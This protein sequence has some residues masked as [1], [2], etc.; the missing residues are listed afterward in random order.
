MNRLNALMLSIPL[1]IVALLSVGCRQSAQPIPTPDPNT[2]QIALDY[3]QTA[4]VG[5]AILRVTLTN[6]DGSP[7]TE[8]Q[9]VEVRGDMTHAGMRPEF[10]N[11]DT[12]EA[13]VY[14]IPF[15]WS[16]GGDW[17]VTVTVTLADGSTVSRVFELSVRT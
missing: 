9:Q 13:G 4:T 17:I 15:N 5:D 1:L 10:G 16:M 8:A 6:P 7:Y 12:G 2:V 14:E 11:A 3:G